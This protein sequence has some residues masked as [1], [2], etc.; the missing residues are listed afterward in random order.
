M[1]NVVV[2]SLRQAITPVRLM[3]R[4][5]AV[6]RMLIMGIG[7]LGGPVG[8]VLAGWLGLRPALW[9]CAVGSIVALLVLFPRPVAR[10][11]ALPDPENYSES[12]MSEENKSPH[13]A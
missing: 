1:M 3:G 11:K 7:A 12:D 8:G 4:M 9:V 6:M 5:N 13:R 2:V 10:L